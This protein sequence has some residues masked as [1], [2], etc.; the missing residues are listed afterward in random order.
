MCFGGGSSRPQ[1]TP[2]PTQD[3][4]NPN[5]GGTAVTNAP[6]APTNEV[7]TEN[8]TETERPRG[9]SSLQ[10]KRNRSRGSVP[11]SGGSDSGL[12]IPT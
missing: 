11:N 5:N 10:I 2:L 12:N 9:V 4:G 6:P 8:G 3:E 7:P 1:P